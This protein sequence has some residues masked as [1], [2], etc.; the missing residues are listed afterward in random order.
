MEQA[1]HTLEALIAI[2]HTI[3]SIER[4]EVLLEKVL[5]V[6]METLGAERGFILLKSGEKAEGFEVKSSFN[7]SHSQLDNTV[8]VSTSVVHHV[9]QNGE[10]VLVYE[11]PTDE[12]F[13]T[14]DSI[15]LQKI[16]SIACVPLT[17]MKRQIGAIY[18]DCLSDRTRFKRTNLPFLGA[19]ASLAAIA[20]EKVG[21]TQALKEE[22]QQLR[23]EVQRTFKV[24][25]IIGKSPKMKELFRLISLLA[26][27][28]TSALVLGESGVGKELVARAIHYNGHRKNKPFLALF[29]GSLPDNLLESEL[30][31]Y[32]RGAFTGAL[33]DKIGLFEAAHGGTIFLDEVGD[34]SHSLQTALLRVLQEGEIKRLG[35][36]ETRKVDVRIISA[37]NKPLKE[38]VAAGDFREDLYYRLNTI[39]LSVPSLRERTEDIPLLANHFLKKLADEG[40]DVSISPET[41]RMLE[42]YRWPGNVRELEN[43]IER[44]L[45]LVAGDTITPAE[46]DLQADEVPVS[47]VADTQDMYRQILSEGAPLM[48]I[49]RQLVMA[50]LEMHNQN[51]SQAARKLGVTRSWIHYRMKKW[52]SQTA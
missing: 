36:N 40:Q 1:Q 39:A 35:E 28:D 4:S 10:P 33:T 14:A 34:L 43:V 18:L 42:S 8:R 24:T 30:F 48:E 15:V 26:N 41:L 51:L 3:N 50:S 9:L 17:S 19:F 45:V 21:A 20:I 25:E 5:E 16:Q 6:A 7:F 49:E 13:Q 52:D 32:K 12:R 23:Q 38:M 11:A 29:C 44:A 31:G 2:A 37:T 46:F 47:S 27:K 22:N